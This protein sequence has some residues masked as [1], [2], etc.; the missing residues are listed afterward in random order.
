[1]NSIFLSG[2]ILSNGTGALLRKRRF[3]IIRIDRSMDTL[4][5]SID[6]QV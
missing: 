5:G 1:M 4:Y 3:N 2:Q 6:C